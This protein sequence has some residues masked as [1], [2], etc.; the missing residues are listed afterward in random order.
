MSVRLIE[1]QKYAV[2]ISGNTEEKEGRS[3]YGWIV[4]VQFPTLRPFSDCLYLVGNRTA[5]ILLN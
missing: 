2:D 1:L 5:Q 4:R 3:P